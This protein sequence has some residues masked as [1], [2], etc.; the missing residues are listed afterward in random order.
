[1]RIAIATTGRFHVLDLARELAALGHEVRF[2]SYVPKRRAAAFG[3][4][5]RCHR[6]L[7]R[8]T[9]PYLAWQH[10]FRTHGEDTR[11]ALL[12]KA[13]NNA[14]IRRLE[15][16]DV[17]IGMSGVYLEAAEYAR[18]KYGAL[19]YLE[20]GSVHI[21]TQNAILKAAHAKPISPLTLMRERAGYALADRISIPSHHVAESFEAQ[22]AGMAAK[23]FVNPYGVDLDMFPQRQAPSPN[24]RRVLFVGTWSYQKGVDVLSKAIAGLS[25]C[26]LVHVGAIGDAPLPDAPWFTHHD[27]VDQTA[28]THFYQQAGAFVLP[29]RQ[30]GFGMVLLQAL[31][32]GLPIIC[33]DRTGGRDA[34]H[35]PALSE[36]IRIVPSADIDAMRHAIAA[37]LEAVAG[38]RIPALPE[39]D[40]QLLSWRGYGERYAAEID[41]AI[42]EKS[43]ERSA[44][45]R[46][47]QCARIQ[48]ADAE[49][50]G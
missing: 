13:L 23:T 45:V 46:P 24:P 34:R 22:Q 41:R 10:L 37:T 27:P 9:A 7:L 8:D 28:L 12:F 1:M 42:R 44:Q 31:A 38:D 3:L 4:P 50:I 11:Q 14:V 47:A 48:S 39:A 49:H 19:V 21:D 29:S 40:R 18:T 2:Y 5:E 35:S 6:S 25:D 26:E 20:R 43:S 36:R 17:F 32:S 30:D 15:P 33:T 16:C